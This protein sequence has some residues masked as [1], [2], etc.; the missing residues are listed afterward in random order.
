MHDLYSLAYFPR[1]RCNV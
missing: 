1:I